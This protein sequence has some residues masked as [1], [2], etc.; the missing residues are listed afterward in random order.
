LSEAG[1]RSP[2]VSGVRVEILPER[3]ATVR[4]DGPTGSVQ[5]ADLS[6]GTD[7][8]GRLWGAP[9]LERLANSYWRYLSRISLGLVR[10]V[11]AAD[12]RSVVLVHHRLLLLR[13]RPPVYDSGPEFGQVTWPIDRGLLVAAPGR[14]HLRISVR[15]L[16]PVPG[17]ETGSERVRVRSE[18]QNFYPLLRGRGRFSRLGA[19]LYS[20]TQLRIHVRVTRGF[21]RSLERFDLEA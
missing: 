4:P 13:F 11:H 19:H 1:P 16:P 20:K 15:R 14:G 21:L 12:S 3:S 7:L 6:A 2:G 9:S 10:V 18:V 8:L 5:E 17:E